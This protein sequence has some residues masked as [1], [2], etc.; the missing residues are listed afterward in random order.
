MK[1]LIGILLIMM[2]FAVPALAEDSVTI[3]FVGDCS[4]GDSAFLHSGGSAGHGLCRVGYFDYCDFCC[5]PGYGAWEAV[6]RAGLCSG[7]ELR[8][9][10]LADI[11]YL[12]Q[13]G[14]FCIDGICAYFPL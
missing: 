3:S 14:N 1:K 9:Q 13:Y 11:W 2:A 6:V 10:E 5:D 7:D 12:G 8:V 4:I